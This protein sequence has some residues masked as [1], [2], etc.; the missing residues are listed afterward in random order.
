MPSYAGPAALVRKELCYYTRALPFAVRSWYPA[1]GQ[2]QHTVAT[3]PA[4]FLPHNPV[5]THFAL[6]RELSGLNGVNPG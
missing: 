5:S 6:R 2:T 4:I 1:F 3:Y